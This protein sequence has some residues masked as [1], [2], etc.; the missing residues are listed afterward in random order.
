MYRD[1]QLADQCRED[2][3]REERIRAREARARERAVRATARREAWRRFERNCWREGRYGKWPC[4]R[5]AITV[6]LVV[7]L[8][9]IG[10]SWIIDSLVLLDQREKWRIQAVRLTNQTA[11]AKACAADKVG[12]LLDVRYDESRVELC[13]CRRRTGIT[14]V[15]APSYGVKK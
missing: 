1:Q 15:L 10:C 12:A 5:S 9:A 2:V 3:E 8:I 7:S 6:G 11:C 13:H 14:F 4:F